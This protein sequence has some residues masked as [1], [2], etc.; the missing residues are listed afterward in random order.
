MSDEEKPITIGKFFES[1]IDDEDCRVIKF[2]PV[3]LWG[4]NKKQGARVKIVL[5]REICGENLKDLNK[6][7]LF[8]VAIKLNE[9]ENND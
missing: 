4:A 5:P 3:E 7:N 9:V 8:V 2:A 1:V 6:W